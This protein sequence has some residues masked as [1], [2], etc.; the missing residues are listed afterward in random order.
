VVFKHLK[1]VA[2]LAEYKGSLMMAT[3][4]QHKATPANTRSRRILERAGRAV[5]NYGFTLIQ[6][7][8]EGTRF[9]RTD[10]RFL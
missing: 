4:A 10:L 9:A 6:L 5:L 2:R 8:F 3:V 7:W 1:N